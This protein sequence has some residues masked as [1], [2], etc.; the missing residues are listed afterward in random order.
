MAGTVAEINDYKNNQSTDFKNHVDS[1]FFNHTSPAVALLS[2]KASTT[3]NR[4]VV[5]D[6]GREKTLNVP[7]FIEIAPGQLKEFMPLMT[8]EYENNG[9][10]RVFQNIKTHKMMVVTNCISYA[11]ILRLPAMFYALDAGLL[12]DYD[13]H[14][15]EQLQN[16]LTSDISPIQQNVFNGVVEDYLKEMPILSTYLNEIANNKRRSL[17]AQQKTEME[18][19]KVTIVKAETSHISTVISRT[20][21]SIK[22]YE[23]SLHSFY[24]LLNE[25]NMKQLHLSESLPL[26]LEE[27]INYLMKN[28]NVIDFEPYKY[29]GNI[30]GLTIAFETYLDQ[31]EYDFAKVVIE[32]AIEKGGVVRDS[33]DLRALKV[34]KEIYLE[35]NYRLKILQGITLRFTSQELSLSEGIRTRVLRE[36]DND[37]PYSLNFPNPHIQ[38]HACFGTAQNELRKALANNN[39][40]YAVDVMLNS[41]KNLNFSDSVVFKRTVR[42]LGNQWGNKILEDY[43][44][45]YFTPKEVWQKIEAVEK[46]KQLSEKLAREEAAAIE[47]GKKL[48]KM[49]DEAMAAAM[50]RH[51]VE[52][53]I[54]VEPVFD[55]DD[56]EGNEEN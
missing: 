39:Y 38:Y 31:F 23:E 29:D 21:N 17:E 34:L 24:K 44:G 18:E 9:Y 26:E 32:T 47:L 15:T 56:I 13:P 52:I 22:D 8:F 40:T 25:N 5:E 36:I 12:R 37:L 16:I 19:L 7:G 3:R 4:N 35:T 41:A 20:Q 1:D 10:F 11:G 27:M 42:E 53:N 30:R 28:E 14:V 46:A 51:G 6:F 45:N 43:E 50:D 54:P 49:E 2:F 33:S 48:Q 55:L